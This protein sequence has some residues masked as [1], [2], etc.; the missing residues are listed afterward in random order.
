[1]KLAQRLCRLD[2]ELLDEAA[3]S[4]VERRQ[5][6]GLSSG[7][8]QREHLQLHQALLEGMGDDHGLELAEQLAVA[9]QLEVKLDPLND[10]AQPL[11]LKPGALGG[12]HTVRRHAAER[13]PAPQAE[14]PLDPRPSGG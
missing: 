11:L 9:T 3:A 5:G 13:L 12:Q 10:R 14:G 7:A 8:I 6:V 4:G 1:M 2:A